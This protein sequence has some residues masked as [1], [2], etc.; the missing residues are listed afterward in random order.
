MVVLE[1]LNIIMLWT[2]E[3]EAWGGMIIIVRQREKSIRESSETLTDISDFVW[4][5]NG[6]ALKHLNG[7]VQE[8][9]CEKLF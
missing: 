3:S 5:A 9:K 8:H 4:C 1:A 7:T 6:A 2:R